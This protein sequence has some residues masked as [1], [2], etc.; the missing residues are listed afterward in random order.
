MTNDVTYVAQWTANSNTAYTVEY[1]YQQLDGKYP[2]DADDT[3]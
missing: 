3:A 1:Y 2:T